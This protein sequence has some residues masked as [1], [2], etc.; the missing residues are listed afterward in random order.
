MLRRQVLTDTDL[1]RLASAVSFQNLEAIA[2]RKLDVGLVFLQDLPT[3]H[4]DNTDRMKT[5][6]LLHWRNK[7]GEGRE[8]RH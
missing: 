5:E 6:V 7:S 2:T 3:Q 4:R 1:S 8:V